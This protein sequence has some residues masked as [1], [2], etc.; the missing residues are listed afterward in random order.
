M[1]SHSIWKFIV[2]KGAQ[3]RGSYWKFHNLKV[4][5]LNLHTLTNIRISAFP[6]ITVWGEGARASS[7]SVG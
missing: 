4:K 6:K 1:H 3:N 5:N 7:I 2:R